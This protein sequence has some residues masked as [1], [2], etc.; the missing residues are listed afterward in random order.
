MNKIRVSAIFSI[1]FVL[2]CMLSAVAASDL[3]TTDTIASEITDETITETADYNAKSGEILTANNEFSTFNNLDY[4]ISC[5]ENLAIL[6]RDYA[7][8]ATHDSGYVNGIGIHRNDLVIDGAGHTIDG[9]NLARMFN[10]T[11]TNVTFKN[12]NFINGFTDNKGGALYITGTS[13]NIINCTFKNNK[14]TVESGAVFLQSFNATIK[15]SIFINNSA[16]YNGA[17]LVRGNYTTIDNCLF[18]DNFA[19]ISAGAVGWGRRENGII[20][21]SVF[22]NNSAVDEGGGAIFWNN[23]HNCKIINSTFLNNT[24]KPDAGAIFIKDSKNFQIVGTAFEGNNATGKG[25][26]VYWFGGD[27]TIQHST[28]SSNYADEDGG[29]IYLRVENGIIKDSNFTNNRAHYNGAVYLNSIQGT[30]YECKFTNNTATDSAGALGWVKKENGTIAYCKFTDNSAPR[31]GAIYLN[32]GTEFYIRNSVFENNSAIKHGGAIFWD[33]G[34]EGRLIGCE[35]KNNT[36]GE[37]GGAVCWNNTQNGYIAHSRFNSNNAHDGGAIYI[38]ESNMTITYSSFTQNTAACGG[39]IY[40]NGTVNV[41]G[42]AF[43]NNR[44]LDGT[45]DTAGSGKIRYNVGFEIDCTDNVYGKTAKITVTLTNDG[46]VINNG[47]ISFTVN[48]ATY[49]AEVRNS[50]ATVEIPNLNAGSYDINIT[51]AGNSTYN[52]HTE[53]YGLIISK[54]DV[55]ITGKDKSL[56]INYGGKYSVT[57][58][59]LS[60]AK[61]IFRLNYKVIKSAVTDKNGI[62]SITLT[63]KML[64]AA[65]AGKRNLVATLD[66]RNYQATNSFKITINKEKTKITAKAKSFKK[67]KKTKKYTITLKNSKGKAVKKVKVTLKVKG[68]TYNAKTNSKGKATFNIKKLTKKGKYTAKISFKGN[69]CYKS[70]A[71]K[72]KIRVK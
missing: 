52:S 29:A 58:K 71:K 38:G 12:I 59:G 47:T 57:V 51:Y 45:N 3:N 1:L 9:G 46:D 11:G 44:A 6:D 18:K 2:L 4:N 34:N 67:S 27:G 61:V 42:N 32:N 15:D 43:T 53:M 24:G 23:A 22:I 10:V 25:G 36:A 40:N 62:A 56:I 28:F 41:K 50:T 14:A 48:S 33:S 19:D 17:V 5:C 7:F 69:A 49:E 60:G 65:K 68:K 37:L 30:V 26:A 55:E 64:K 35:F 20:K 70:S 66:D 39:A 21:N 16:I 63:S 8:N 72:V 13:S 31:G 54:K